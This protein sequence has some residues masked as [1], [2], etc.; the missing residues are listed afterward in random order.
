MLGTDILLALW[1]VSLFAG[2]AY[3]FF[4]GAEK[5]LRFCAKCRKSGLWMSDD[6]WMKMADAFGKKHP[7]RR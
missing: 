6:E 5:Q 3:A 1:A 7:G 2:C 4:K